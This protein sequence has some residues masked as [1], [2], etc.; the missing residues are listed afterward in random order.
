M[1]GIRSET[2]ELIRA[3]EDEFLAAA[4]LSFFHDPALLSEIL[5]Q[6]RS[7]RVMEVIKKGL[8]EPDGA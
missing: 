8:E 4:F 5:H 6:Q 3:K 7:S 2:N 1:H